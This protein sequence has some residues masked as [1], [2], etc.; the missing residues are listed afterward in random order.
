MYIKRI[1]N[2]NNQAYKENILR[3]KKIKNGIVNANCSVIGVIGVS[4]ATREH[5]EFGDYHED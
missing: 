4:H 5:G 1:F 2:M 3:C